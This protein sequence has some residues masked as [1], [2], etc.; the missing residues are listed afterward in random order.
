MKKIYGLILLYTLNCTAD[1]F[2]LEE[3]STETAIIAKNSPNLT[4]C[5]PQNV[6]ES[7]FLAFPFQQLKFV[8]V[9]KNGQQYKA[10]FSYQDSQLFDFEIND[11]LVHDGIQITQIDLKKVTV[12]DWSKSEICTT[13]KKIQ[14][15]L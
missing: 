14:L 8:G 6:A 3:K 13:P 4:A 10:L 11:L 15:K 12:I 1:P 7:H 5:M 9:I 2:Y